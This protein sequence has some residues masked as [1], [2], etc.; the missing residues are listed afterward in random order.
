MFIF[1]V[2]MEGKED[3]FI[4]RGS[5]RLPIPSNPNTFWLRVSLRAHMCG[6]QHSFVVCLSIHS[7][8]ALFHLSVHAFSGFRRK[9]VSVA[10][11]LENPEK[12][13][14]LNTI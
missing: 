4:A 3:N 14:S 12:Y 8:H 9:S 6:P 1:L 5:D 13:V 11:K 2:P 7:I 10:L